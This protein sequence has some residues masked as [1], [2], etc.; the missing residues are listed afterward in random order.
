MEKNYKK[1]NERRERYARLR[2]E[3]KVTLVYADQLVEEMG[4]FDG[5]SQTVNKTLSHSK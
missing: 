5:V 3:L 2:N 1:I 4:E